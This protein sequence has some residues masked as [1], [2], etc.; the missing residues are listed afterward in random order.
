[1]E[2]YTFFDDIDDDRTF[3]AADFAEHLAT[4]FTNGIFNNG[5][6]VAANDDMSITIREGHANIKGYRYINTDDLTL[7][8]QNADGILNRIDN[9]VIR[10]DLTNRLISTQ[11]IKGTFTQNAVAPNLVRNSTTYDLRI[12]KINVKA[13]STKITQDLIIDTRNITSDCGNVVSAVQTLNSDEIFAQYQMLFDNFMTHIKGQLDTDIAGHLQ[14]ELDELDLTKLDK[15]NPIMEILDDGTFDLKKD[16]LFK[17]MSKF[18]ISFNTVTRYTG[19]LNDINRTCLLYAN[20]AEGMPTST[21]GYIFT[22]TFNASYRKQLF[23]DVASN[24]SYQRTLNNGTWT[25]WEPDWNN[26]SNTINKSA[27]GW[28]KL[29]N[30]AIRQW[31]AVTV[32][33]GTRTQNITFPIAFPGRCCIVMPTY[34]RTD[35]AGE[36]TIQPDSTLSETGTGLCLTK[37]SGS[38]A[39]TAAVYVRWEAFGW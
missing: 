4:F 11:I 38:S 10:L 18:N 1:M 12:A 16:L 25:G 6:Q 26:I 14:L 34:L 37:V 15:D 17:D 2:K 30:G 28:E 13:G 24:R 19:N 7:Q 36:L 39:P 3:F 8:I 23:L 27:N 31:G 35:A 29:A 22:M 21:N 20:G 5:L 32:A 9:V 33:S